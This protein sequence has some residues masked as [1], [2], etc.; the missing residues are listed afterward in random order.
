MCLTQIEILKKE[1]GLDYFTED[2]EKN[3]EKLR[4]IGGDEEEK[5]E[6]DD[7][8]EDNEN[9]LNKKKIKAF[10]KNI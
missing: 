4:K 3:L 1:Y 10:N 7:D 8:N 2:T 6:E 9:I 5:E